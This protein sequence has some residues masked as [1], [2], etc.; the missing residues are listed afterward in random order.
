LIEVIIGLLPQ[1]TVAWVTRSQEIDVF[2]PTTIRARLLVS[3]VLLAV[4]PVIAV[5]AGSLTVACYSGRRQVAD[6][7][8][9]V[10]ELKQSAIE[11][12]IHGIEEDLVVASNTDCAFERIAVVLT[13]SNDYK[14]YGFY[15]RAVRKRLQVLVGQSPQLDALFLIDLQ[16]QVTL[17]TD[18]DEEGTDLSEQPF[19]HGG[20]LA[21]TVHI[22]FQGNGASTDALD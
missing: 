18:V 5:T 20:L 10:A 2:K 14:H 15:N 3:F 7:L 11:S 9:S 21:P 17:S 12:W 13:L 8:A 16:G 6:R 22:P 19:F 4:L 1:S